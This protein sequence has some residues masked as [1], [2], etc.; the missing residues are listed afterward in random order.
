[1]IDIQ[2]LKSPTKVIR[3]S[4]EERFEISSYVDGDKIQVFALDTARKCVCNKSYSYLIV[5][6]K[7]FIIRRVM[8]VTYIS[9]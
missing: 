5:S 7:H 8:G 2:T 4:R 1:M 9:Q 6:L 3:V